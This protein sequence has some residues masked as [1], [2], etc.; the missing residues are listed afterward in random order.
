LSEYLIRFEACLNARHDTSKLKKISV[1][2]TAKKG[3]AE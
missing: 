1:R 2:F 3:S